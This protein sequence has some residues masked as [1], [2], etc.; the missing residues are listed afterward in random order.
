MTQRVFNNHMVAHVWANQSQDSGRSHNGNFSFDGPTLYSYREPIGYVVTSA[1]PASGITVEKAV[2]ITSNS[3]SVTTSGK[4]INPA[5]RAVAYGRNYPVFYVPYIPD[6]NTLASYMSED[7]RHDNWNKVHVINGKHF[8]D[9]LRSLYDRAR[10]P[11]INF[12]E[13]RNQP[14]ESE[15]ERR[16]SFLLDAFDKGLQAYCRTFGFDVPEINRDL[17]HDEIVAAFN[18]YNDPKAVAKREKA[19]EQRQARVERQAAAQADSW[20]DRWLAWRLDETGTV[21]LPREFSPYDRTYGRKARNY[22]W[23]GRYGQSSP[24]WQSVESANAW[25]RYRQ[26]AERRAGWLAGEANYF[27]GTDEQGGALLRV[28]GD[29]IETSLGA[30]V[31]LE[32]GT[33][34]FRF[35]KLVRARGEV[36]RRNGH[37]IRVG[38][39][40]VDEIRPDG[41]IRAGCHLINWPEIERIARQIGVFDDAPSDAAVTVSGV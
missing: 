9:G 8:L 38:H 4:H 3:F 18:R 11:H 17:W 20:L 1:D 35:I 24:E 23:S 27:R 6:R 26:E 40:T 14:G 16:F 30:Q 12:W 33:R 7:T 41:A 29:Q 21:E 32:H 34:A 39:F 25:E 31:P 22:R 15:A 2:L 28:R 37:S 19:V 36:W 10:K 13:S 5:N